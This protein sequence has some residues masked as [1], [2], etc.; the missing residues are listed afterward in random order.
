[1]N[2]THSCTPALCTRSI[3]FSNFPPTRHPSNE[4]LRQ[5]CTAKVRQRLHAKQIEGIVS[6]H[7]I[8]TYGYINLMEGFLLIQWTKSADFRTPKAQDLTLADTQFWLRKDGL[9][10]EDRQ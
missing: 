2:T 5:N 4:Q 1:M 9:V 10:N 8:A 6:R 3:F 7:Y